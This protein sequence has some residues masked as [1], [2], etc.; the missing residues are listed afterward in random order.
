MLVDLVL[1]FPKGHLSLVCGKLGIG[2]TLSLLGTSYGA[3]FGIILNVIQ[4]YSARQT[5]SPARPFV[6]VHHQ[7]AY[8]KGEL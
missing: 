4:L 8:I 7:I 1:K 3:N 6:R 2:K 5:S